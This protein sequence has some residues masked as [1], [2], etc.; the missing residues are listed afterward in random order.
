MLEV[1]LNYLQILLHALRTKSLFFRHQ[2]VKWSCLEYTLWQE[3]SLCDH[4]AVG[5]GGVLS[6]WSQSFLS[7]FRE[8]MTKNE[9]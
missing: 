1:L 5:K 7:S 8:I 6:F 3:W 9:N 4:N 2:K